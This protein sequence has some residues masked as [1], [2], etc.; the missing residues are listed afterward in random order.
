MRH[1][2]SSLKGPGR[3]PVDWHSSMRGVIPSVGALAGF[4]RTHHAPRG[5]FRRRI[6]ADLA[7]RL[8]SALV[9]GG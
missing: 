1:R 6:A 9:D 3:V 5:C 2:H 4:F 7:V 8:V